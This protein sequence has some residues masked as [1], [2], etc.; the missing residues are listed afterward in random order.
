MLDIIVF[1]GDATELFKLHHR[2]RRI[3]A[4]RRPTRIIH[5]Y[6]LGTVFNRLDRPTHAIMSDKRLR[7]PRRVVT[8]WR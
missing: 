8:E 1:D 3:M 6:Y 5:K 2:G 7:I 4:F